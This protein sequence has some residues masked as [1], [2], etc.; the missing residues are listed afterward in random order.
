MSQLWTLTVADFNYANYTSKNTLTYTA[1]RKDGLSAQDESQGVVSW[2]QADPDGDEYPT[3]WFQ[4]SNNGPYY[5]CYQQIQPFLALVNRMAAERA[6]ECMLIGDVQ[7]MGSYIQ[8]CNGPVGSGLVHPPRDNTSIPLLKNPQSSAHPGWAKDYLQGEIDAKNIRGSAILDSYMH[9]LIYI[10][11][12]KP[13]VEP[14]MGNG[15]DVWAPSVFGIQPQGRGTLQPCNPGTGTPIS[16]NPTT[17]PD[18]SNLMHSDMRYWAAPGYEL[19]FELWSAGPD[20]QFSWWRD[21]Q[22]N[23]DNIA[24][25]PY[26]QGIG[27]QP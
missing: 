21:D 4:A 5:F 19:E 14:L 6:Q 22:R 10:C 13:G 25:E 16:G 17:L 18:P 23:R 11:Q 26:N 9:P 8:G 7:Q 27:T 1:N 2:S 12:V 15:I 20:G 3:G 24:C